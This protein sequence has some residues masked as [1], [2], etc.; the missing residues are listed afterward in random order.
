MTTA[1]AS[2][3]TTA[4]CRAF[5]G[6]SLAP[7][8]RS[9]RDRVCQYARDYTLLS[10]AHSSSSLFFVFVVLSFFV[11]VMFFASSLSS[12]LP[13]SSSSAIFGSR[14][15]NLVW[16]NESGE[17]GRRMKRFYLQLEVIVFWM[18]PVFLVWVVKMLAVEAMQ[19]RRDQVIALCKAY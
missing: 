5:C 8:V 6:Q 2:E 19:W 13:S 18:D 16:M 14:L 4:R 3:K 12:S 15:T 1:S 9:G 17:N 11:F 10:V 7:H